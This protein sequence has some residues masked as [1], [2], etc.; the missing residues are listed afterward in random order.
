MSIVYHAELEEWRVIDDFPRYAVS[1]LGRVKRIARSERNHGVTD[2]PLKAGSSPRGYLQVTLSANGRARTRRVNRLVCEAFHG[3]P[4]T[5]KHHAAHNDGDV[6]NNRK[7]N[8]RWATG[9]ENE[10]DKRVH[11]TAA[12]GDRHWSKLQPEKRATGEGHGLAKLKADDIPKIRADKRY[13][14]TIAAEFGVTQRTIWMVKSGK[15]WRHVP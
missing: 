8:L 14:R 13:Q 15:T 5:A 7:D 12:I 6:S 10:A 2:I 9:K 11:G 1:S 4:P 3:L